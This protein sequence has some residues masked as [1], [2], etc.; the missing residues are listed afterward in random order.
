MFWAGK[1]SSDIIDEKQG[2]VKSS[3]ARNPALLA[4]RSVKSIFI[5]A[6]KQV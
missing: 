6:G 2:S 5:S 3:S 1:Q 4:L